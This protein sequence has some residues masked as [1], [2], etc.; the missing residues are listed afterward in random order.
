MKKIIN[1]KVYDTETA[2]FIGRYGYGGYDDLD[3]IRRTL[4]RKKNGEFFE[5]AEGGPNTRY[6]KQISVSNWSGGEVIKPLSY[7]EAQKFAEEYLTAEEYENCFGIIEETKECIRKEFTLKVSTVEKI[8]RLATK[9]GITMQQFIE[10]VVD[11]I[12][13]QNGEF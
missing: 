9:R 13:N 1:N 6:A 12:E 7:E 3:C 5:H 11:T 10:D 2:K 4:Y 8:K